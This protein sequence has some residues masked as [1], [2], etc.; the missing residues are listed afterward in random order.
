MKS[1]SE[2]VFNKYFLTHHI[3]STNIFLKNPPENT[4]TSYRIISQNS[5]KPLRSPVQH[6]SACT[7]PLTLI[8]LI[9]PSRKTR[10]SQGDAKRRFACP[11]SNPQ[12]KPILT[13]D[14]SSTLPTNWPPPSQLEGCGLGAGGC[15]PQC[16][17]YVQQL[18]QP[19]NS[20]K[21]YRATL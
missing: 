12:Q 7:Q 17:V 19:L 5:T 18:L 6:H 9:S 14:L 13:V 11:Q 1:Y 21:H 2:S 20:I 16:P 8:L 3:S 15:H 10:H 4:Q